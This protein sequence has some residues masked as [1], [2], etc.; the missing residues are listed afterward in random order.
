MDQH[1]YD[2]RVTELDFGQWVNEASDNHHRGASYA[3]NHAS[4]V[5]SDIACEHIDRTERHALIDSTYPLEDSFDDNLGPGNSLDYDRT[6]A[7]EKY[8]RIQRMNE[9]GGDADV[10][11]Q[12]ECDSFAWNDMPYT[13]QSTFRVKLL[14]RRMP[15]LTERRCR[16]CRF[17]GRIIDAQRLP[18]N[19]LR[20]L[21]LSGTDS[22]SFNSVV[23]AI[24]EFG[25]DRKLD[26]LQ[27]RPSLG[28]EH[29]RSFKAAPHLIIANF[30]PKEN[31]VE[32]RYY[33]AKHVDFDQIRGWIKDCY[34]NHGECCSGDAHHSLRQL[35]VIDCGSNIVVP[36]PVGCHYVALS[37]VWGQHNDAFDDLQNPPKTIADSI[38]LTQ[39]LGY[40][41]LWIDRFVCSH[42]LPCNS[43]RLTGAVHR[44]E[45][46]CG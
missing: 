10:Y 4:E 44:S 22:P 35:R 19:K 33:Q 38:Y 32:K 5:L 26:I 37:Y 1:I 36:A 3:R 6:S 31:S 15:Q 17:I 27:I 23:S 29:G 40:Q 11:Q 14:S 30:P 43:T 2:G 24:P 28:I 8:F 42:D 39:R 7:D 13:W 16:I 12:C 9:H 25:G 41:Y 45:R 20:D 34:M 46:S 18:E 21:Y